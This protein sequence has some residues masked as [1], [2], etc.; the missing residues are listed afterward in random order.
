MEIRV[1]FIW[2]LH[3]LFS[4]FPFQALYTYINSIHIS[5]SITKTDV[6]IRSCIEHLT[7]TKSASFTLQFNKKKPSLTDGFYYELVINWF[8]LL[9]LDHPADSCM[10]EIRQQPQMHENT[11]ALLAHRNCVHWTEKL[12]RQRCSRNFISKHLLFTIN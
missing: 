8:G 2:Y 1:K 12:A 6:K 3:F 5:A 10:Q 11:H 7:P 9:F 4:T